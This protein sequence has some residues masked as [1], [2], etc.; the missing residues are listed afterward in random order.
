MGK[1][2]ISKGLQASYT[3]IGSKNPETIY[4]CTDTGNMYLGETPLYAV[5]AFTNAELTGKTL[6]FTKKNGTN[7]EVNLSTFATTEEVASSIASLVKSVTAT[8]NAG[9]EVG[10]TAIN[11]T[12]GIK[13][14]GDTLLVGADGLSVNSSKFD[15]A[16]AADA[17]KVAVIGSDADNSSSNT[18][19]GAKKYADEK[20][21]AQIASTY[22]YKG[23]CTYEELPADENQ[24]GDVWNVTDAH[25][26]VPAGT[27][28]AWN[29][30][31]WDAL[32]GVVDLTPYAKTETV[33]S[34]YATKTEVTSGLGSKVDKTTTINSKPLS[35]NVTLAGGDITLTGYAK[36]DDSGEI[37]VNDTIN[38][39]IG[40]L[41]NRISAAEVGG[42]T[43]ISAS[44]NSLNFSNTTGA[45]TANVKLSVTGENILTLEADGLKVKPMEW[46]TF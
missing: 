3:G 9:I 25:D 34:T 7:L 6:R 26:N 12:I 13:L 42:V 28:Y 17:A 33:A 18:I 1:L 43:S 46:G 4:I 36:G 45:I 44:D 11:P 32:A 39:A 2:I 30:T 20:I 16:G 23:S 21:T 29:G 37:S 5:G 31:A 38:S 27:N 41:E 15:A 14:N 35:A 10:G 8:A 19:Y 24:V 22:K 40:K